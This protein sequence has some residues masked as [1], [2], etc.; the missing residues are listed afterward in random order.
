MDERYSGRVTVEAR[1][2]ADRIYL[3]LRSDILTGRLSPGQRLPFADLCERYDV[4]IG[5]LREVLPRLTEQGLVSAEPQ[6]GFRVMSISEEDLVQLTEARVAVETLVLRQSVEHGDL[7]WESAVLGAHHTLARTP[8]RTAAGDVN[9]GWL[10]AHADYHEALLTASPN[11][12]LF[13]IANRLR[14]EGELYRVWAHALPQ[15]KGRDVTR[16]HRRILDATL[17]RDADRAVDEL[18]AHIQRSTKILLA[19]RRA[20]EGSPVRPTGNRPSKRS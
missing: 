1:T 18:T 7:G 20:A 14:D 4:S 17:A 6:I 15:A 12:R 13:A 11:R 5:V 3:Q 19:G 16:E 8:T 10:A 9:E 2:R